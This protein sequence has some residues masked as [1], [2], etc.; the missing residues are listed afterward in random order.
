[1]IEAKVDQFNLVLR[2]HDYDLLRQEE[3]SEIAQKIINTFEDQTKINKLFG[4][5]KETDSFT[6]PGYDVVFNFNRLPAHAIAFSINNPD[7]GV[8]ISTNAHFWNIWQQ[9]YYEEFGQRLEL[10]KLFKAIQN[11]LLYTTHFSRVDLAI[12]FIDEGLDVGKLYRSIMDG[13]SDVYYD[14]ETKKDK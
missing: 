1:M 11:P 7:R 6:P 3:W 5:L 4:E 9:R 14:S 10:Y 13:R 12:D 2:P 8:L